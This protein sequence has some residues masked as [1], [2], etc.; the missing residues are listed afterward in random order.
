L[1]K[2]LKPPVTQEPV[3]ATLDAEEDFIEK[4][5]KKKKEKQAT[6]DAAA[7]AK[8]RFGHSNPFEALA[9]AASTPSSSRPASAA[10]QTSTVE[11]KVEIDGTDS[12]KLIPQWDSD[13]WKTYG[14]KLRVYGTQEEE[15]DLT[16]KRKAITA[17]APE[18]SDEAENR[19]QDGLEP[20]TAHPR[21][22]SIIS[23][24]QESIQSLWLGKK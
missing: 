12:D 4:L 5:S 24:L 8:S 16:A 19:D 14:N 15:C 17:A 7:A 9:Q 2:T 22:G 10:T 1:P 13:F 18:D 23:T 20:E 21:R 11:S 3:K 6:D